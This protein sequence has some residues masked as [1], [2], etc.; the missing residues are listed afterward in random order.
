MSQR[1]CSTVMCSLCPSHLWRSEAALAA[2]LAN[3]LGSPVWPP[4][5]W[6]QPAAGTTVLGAQAGSSRPPGGTGWRPR[7]E[8]VSNI[9]IHQ[10]AGRMQQIPDGKG[11]WKKWKCAMMREA[12][13]NKS[14]P[15]KK[16]MIL[17][18]R[19]KKLF[20]QDSNLVSYIDPLLIPFMKG[21]IKW[22]NQ[23]IYWLSFEQRYMKYT[24]KTLDFSIKNKR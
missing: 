8:G 11:P 18:L 12:Q 2:G 16:N 7:G 24:F 20:H 17:K 13:M 1:R 23:V 14:F 9:E 10:P 6:P 21:N 3:C 19:W 15:H 4:Y 22:I 5:Q